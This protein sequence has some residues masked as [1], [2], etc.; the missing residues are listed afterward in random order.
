MPMYVYLCEEHGEFEKIK[1][2]SE[3]EVCKCPECDVDCNLVI[4][5]PKLVHGGFYDTNPRMSKN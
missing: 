1:K 5:A 3:R 2:I 4:S